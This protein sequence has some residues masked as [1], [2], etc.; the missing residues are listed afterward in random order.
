MPDGVRPSNAF[1]TKKC[2]HGLRLEPENQSV[3]FGVSLPADW[4]E[5]PQDLWT[6][7]AGV[8]AGRYSTAHQVR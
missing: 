5:R 1:A 6:V 7:L 4:E 2:K 3:E 8:D